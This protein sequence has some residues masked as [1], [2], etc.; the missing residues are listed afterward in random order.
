MIRFALVGLLAWAALAPSGAADASAARLVSPFPQNLIPGATATQEGWYHDPVSPADRRSEVPVPSEPAAVGGPLRQTSATFR[1]AGGGIAVPVS[2]AFGHR[3]ARHEALVLNSAGLF[4]FNSPSPTAAARTDVAE[5]STALANVRAVRCEGY[6]DFGGWPIH[7]RLL[8]DE[9]AGAICRL[10]AAHNRSI[11]TESVG[12]AGAR[13]VLVG[14]SAAERAANRRVIIEVTDTMAPPTRPVSLSVIPG[15]SSAIVTF[16]VPPGGAGSP[17]SVYEYS[18]D[19]GA[20]WSAL[21]TTGANRLRATIVGLVNGRPYTIIVRAAGAAGA[22]APTAALSFIPAGAPAPSGGPAGVSGSVEA[23]AT[24]PGAA[25]LSSVT[26]ESGAATL[27]FSAPASNGGS[28]ITGY[29]YSTDG[30]STWHNATVSGTGPYTANVTGLTN[31]TEYH[32]AVRAVNA[33]G[34]GASSNVVSTTP[35]GVPGAATL[36]SVTPESGAATLHFSAPASNGGS[37]ITGYEYSTDGGSTWHSATVSGSGPYTTTVTGLT[38]GTEYHVAVRAVNSVGNSA[39]SGVVG[40]TP[41]TVPSAPTLSSVTAESASATLHFSA[42]SNNGGFAVSSYQYSTD[43][44]STWHNAT[45]SGSGPY[46]ATVTG[47]TNGTEYQF[48]VRAHN[49]IGNGAASHVVNATPQAPATVPGAPVIVSGSASEE[50]V[51]YEWEVLLN[52]TTPS[53]GGSAITEYLYSINGG[54]YQTLPYA[55]GSPNVGKLLADNLCTTT[56]PLFT[57]PFSATFTVE[58]KNAIGVSL[59]SNSYLV[60]HSDQTLIEDHDCED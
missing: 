24:V 16:I 51:N 1:A 59:P 6:T 36:S 39:P 12:Y 58:A 17:A 35:A 27:H 23:P 18:L 53:N 15:D 29:E 26:P 49:A 14:G 48:A 9:R 5:L 3:L 25:A 19:G 57:A 60:T 28:A 34:N 20:H 2:W 31:G 46:T 22:S 4:D 10:I 55:S 56:G 38:N 37:A 40:V 21:H 7:E 33:V 50:L 41:G 8:S 43:G 45:V 42:P 13:P 54:A 52:F 44:G 11:R 32:F 47:L 30:G